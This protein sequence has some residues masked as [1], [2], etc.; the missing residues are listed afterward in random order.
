MMLFAFFLII[1]GLGFILFGN[2]S[3]VPPENDKNNS[4]QK[5]PEKIV[6]NKWR[7]FGKERKSKITKEIKKRIFNKKYPEK[8]PV[9]K[10][11]MRILKEREINFSPIT[12]IENHP[13]KTDW[14]NQNDSSNSPPDNV[15]IIEDTTSIHYEERTNPIFITGN[16][17]VDFSK[18]IPVQ[19]LVEEQNNPWR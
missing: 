7:N 4:S 5:P 13:P 2:Y 12:P 16:L 9:E 3:F 15:P 10:E 8:P 11:E 14:K 17:F 18:D 1:A 19:L 6:I